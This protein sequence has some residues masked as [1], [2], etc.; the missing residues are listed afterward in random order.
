[1]TD[2]KRPYRMNKRRELQ[3]ATRL[4]ITESAVELHGTLGPARTSMSAVAEHAGVRR[5]TLYRY[6]ADEAE[7]FEACSNHWSHQYP[8]PDFEGW[9]TIRDLQER[10][11]TGLLELY[12]YYAR[13]ERMLTNIFRDLDSMD[14]VK[15]QFEPF[16]HY[17]DALQKTL[18]AGH[19]K[20][21]RRAVHVRAAIGHATA[22]TTWHSLV[23]EQ[24]LTPAEAVE[25]MC[26]LTYA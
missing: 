9:A 26:K 17:L 16:T 23:R 1:M 15:Q 21:G 11:R 3:Q 14:V 22:F 5:S 4:R 2:E 24:G 19:V 6:F 7:L 12:A 10:L 8:V 25:M 20:R 18:L 13:A